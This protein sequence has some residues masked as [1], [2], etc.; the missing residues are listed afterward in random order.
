MPGEQQ[1]VDVEG[2]PTGQK[3]VMSA[4]YPDGSNVSIGTTYSGAPDATGWTHALF[5]WTIPIS[6]T[7]GVAQAIWHIPCG[8]YNPVG[9]NDFTIIPLPTPTPSPV[10]SD[11]PAPSF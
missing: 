9:S 2:F 6:M 8:P 3:I 11:S 1:S 4:H 7:P 5:T 10:I